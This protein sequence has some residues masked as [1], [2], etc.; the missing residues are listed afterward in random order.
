MRY[1]LQKAG[2]LSMSVGKMN[3]RL[4]SGVQECS[5]AEAETVREALAM[6]KRL[7]MGAQI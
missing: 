5:S 1:A 4:L 3:A 6:L 2:W 7:F